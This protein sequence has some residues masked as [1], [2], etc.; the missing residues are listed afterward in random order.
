ME[1]KQGICPK[2]EGVLQVPENLEKIICMYCGEELLT[3]QVLLKGEN[4]QVRLKIDNEELEQSIAIGNQKLPELLLS[5]EN[6]MGSFKKDKYQNSFQALYSRFEDVFAAIDYVYR[7]SE[8][9]EAYIT[10]VAE[11][12][13]AVA[14]ENLQKQ[15]AGKKRLLEQKLMDY[16]FCM[17]IYVMPS[18]LEYKGVSSEALVD[19]LLVQWKQQYP[20]TNLG[21][22]SFDKI[23]EGFRWKL[24]YITTAVCES[25]SKSDDC[26]ELNVLRD[27]RDHYLK[28]I[29]E[30]EA[31]IKEYYDIAPT[32]VKRINRQENSREI[33]KDIWTTY[34]SPCIRM[35]EE[36]KNEE[37]KELY[38][39]M[40]RNLQKE[41][42]GG[43][44]S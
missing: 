9:K 42:S 21:K 36:N 43:T 30:G 25:F 37:C 6:P 13:V 22:S 7:V 34:L 8:D 28:T 16:N 1:F 19:A 17:A 20:K 12:F 31:I 33:Y 15:S 39:K 32:I 2:C 4:Q 26:Y 3:K 18:I 23:V 27:Y 38:I 41:Y 14:D 40:V 29:P 11:N 24:C 10:S 35:V 44:I 5:I